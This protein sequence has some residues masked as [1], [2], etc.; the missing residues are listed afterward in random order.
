M[1]D[2]LVC[3]GCGG[4]SLSQRPFRRCVCNDDDDDADAA[5]THA[6]IFL[7]RTS[8]ILRGF[9]RIQ[10]PTP[11]TKTGAQAKAYAIVHPLVVTGEQRKSPLVEISVILAP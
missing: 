1:L 4:A 7:L 11:K 6:V 8:E 2:L 9:F 10:P 3:L 5:T